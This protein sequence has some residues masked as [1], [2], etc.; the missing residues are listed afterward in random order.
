MKSR[1]SRPHVGSNETPSRE[2]GRK[3][4]EEKATRP[5]TSSLIEESLSPRRSSQVQTFTP[6][7]HPSH[8]GVF[9]FL[10]TDLAPAQDMRGQVPSGHQGD[11]QHVRRRR[12]GQSLALF[13]LN[14]K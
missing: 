14:V 9:N 5:Y 6:V 4:L 11:T 3:S 8:R 1:E 13:L 2:P 12:V 10:A 7:P